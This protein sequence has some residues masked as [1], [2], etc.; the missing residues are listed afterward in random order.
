MALSDRISVL[1]GGRAVATEERGAS[2]ASELLKAMAPRTAASW[3]MAERVALFRER[4]R[5]H[6]GRQPGDAGNSTWRNRRPC[7]PRRPW[8][9]ALPENAGRAGPADRRRGQRRYPAGPR[10]ITSFRKAVA[11]GIAY[12]PRDRAPPASFRPSR[13]LTISPFR[14]CRA[15]CVSV[16]SISPRDGALRGLSRQAL[17]RSTAA[18]RRDHDAVRR[19]PAEG[20]A[21]PGNWRWSRRSSCSTIHA[22]R[23]RGDTPCPLRRVPRAGRR[24]HG[25]GHPVQRDRG[26]PPALPPRAGFSANSNWPAEIA[27]E[28]MA[29]DTVIAAM[30]GR[31][32]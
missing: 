28:A 17:H 26:D 23:R 30:F 6:T 16:C 21:G 22:W 9:G 13:C 24:R 31:A 18:G 29:S 32:A 15:I 11:N 7:R 14:R 1:R 20:A 2:T 5:H 4:P 12:L 8:P 10:A 3:R 27:G 19:Q 25:A